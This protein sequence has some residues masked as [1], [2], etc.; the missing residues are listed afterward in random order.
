VRLKYGNLQKD[1]QSMKAYLT[2]VIFLSTCAA[3]YAQTSHA[4]PDSIIMTCYNRVNGPSPLYLIKIHGTQYIADS[5]LFKPTGAGIL[6]TNWIEHIDILKTAESAGKY[7]E[8]A[9]NGVVLLTLKDSVYSQAFKT[10][11]PYLKKLK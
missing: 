7:M 5:V 11:K 2:I 6:N 8:S 3:D 9:N 1:N 4:K 10:L